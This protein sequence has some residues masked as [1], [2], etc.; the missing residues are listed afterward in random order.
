L[1]RVISN[2]QLVIAEGLDAPIL[3]NKQLINEETLGADK[4]EYFLNPK[5]Q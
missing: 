3:H 5:E 1:A 4:I 2:T